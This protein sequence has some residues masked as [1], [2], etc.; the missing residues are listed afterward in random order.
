MEAMENILVKQI[1]EAATQGEVIIMGDFN[2]PEIDWGTETCSSSKVF[3]FLFLDSIQ[4]IAQASNSLEDGTDVTTFWWGEW[5]K[6]TACTRTCGGGVKSQ[7]RHCLR[8]R[9]KSL[10]SLGNK[11][12][13]GTSKRYQ[14]C[15]VQCAD[16]MV[17]TWLECPSNSRSFREEQ[18]T[19]FNSHVYNGKTYQW[20]PLYPGCWVLDDYVHISSKPC[21]LQ[22]TTVDG[23]RQL[24]VQARDGTSCKYSDYRG[25]CVS[26]KCEPI[27]CDGVLFSTHTLDKCGVCQG[28][29]SSC[30]HVTGNYRKGASH[31]GYALVTYI[32][33]GARDIQIVERKKSADVLAVADESGYYYFNGNF[34]VDT[35][36]NFNIA[37]TI[38]KYRRPMDVYETG[39]EYIVAQGPTNQALNIMVWNQNGKN[40]SITFQY[41]LLRRPNSR[42]TQ[43]I[44]YPFPNSDSEESKEFEED[45]TSQNRSLITNVQKGRA[46]GE[47]PT[48]GRQNSRENGSPV[49]ERNTNEVYEG[50]EAI[51]CEK[52]AK[53]KT[54]K[55]LSTNKTT[56]ISDTGEQDSLHR[57]NSK[58]F[59]P[60]NAIAKKFSNKATGSRE[61]FHHLNR[62]IG[63]PINSVEP[64]LDNLYADY[65]EN[66]DTAAFDWNVTFLEL[67]IN[68]SAETQL[69]NASAPSTN[70]TQKVSYPMF[71]L[72]TGI[73]G[74]WRAVCVTALQ[75]PN[76]D[77]A[78]IRIVVGI[79]AASLSV[80]GVL[81]QNLLRIGRRIQPQRPICRVQ[82]LQHSEGD[83]MKS[84]L[85]YVRTAAS[86]G[87]AH[88]D[89]RRVFLDRSI[90]I[91]LVETL[92]LRKINNPV[93]G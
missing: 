1:D 65:E 27:G 68:T 81:H 55:D 38:F 3:I 92:R 9:R 83:F 45:F 50:G 70:R 66:E 48:F 84:H 73:V 5:T 47:T 8:Q 20:K 88:P 33:V 76:S 67:S 58:E 59:L 22:C 91:Y 40:P 77:A 90:S 61:T 43:P 62:S 28:D 57:Y 32:P 78:A 82:M 13:T 7:E 42:V 49:N 74:R 30:V 15:K 79:A 16:S 17:L 35:P 85:H 18:C 12:C 21:D 34:K 23:Q 75:R 29:G 52:R 4:D 54:I 11:N 37:G 64:N 2:Y 31:L 72:V 25:V 36:K 10:S 26:G 39:I 56:Y 51:D 24:M 53:C 44:Y 19:S 6:W 93:Y 86:D 46:K 41:T 80:T 14:L 63:E 87:P 71:T 69:I 60:G 89:M